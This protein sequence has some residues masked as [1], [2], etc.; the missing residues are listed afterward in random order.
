MKTV[1]LSRMTSNATQGADERLDEV[2][3]G[4]P[5]SSPIA[6]CPQ[7]ILTCIFDAAIEIMEGNDEFV[8]ATALSHVCKR[9]R[10]ISIY[11]PRL[12]RD[13]EIYCLNPIDDILSFLDRMHSRVKHKPVNIFIYDIDNSDDSDEEKE[14]DIRSNL[15]QFRLGRF[16]HIVYLRLEMWQGDSIYEHI[17]GPMPDAFEDCRIDELDLK[18][19]ADAEHPLSWELSS[20]LYRLPTVTFLFLDWV[21]SVTITP[22]DILKRIRFL[23]LSNMYLSLAPVL[24][25]FAHVEEL[26]FGPVKLMDDDQTLSSPLTMNHLRILD[27]TGIEEDPGDT[28]G[29]CLAQLTCPLLASLRIPELYIEECLDFISSHTS[30]IELDLVPSQLIADLIK[31]N[32]QLESFS[33]NVYDEAYEAIW[34]VVTGKPP[35][36]KLKKLT[37]IENESEIFS[38]DHFETLVTKRCLPLAHPQSQLLPSTEPIQQLILSLDKE[39]SKDPTWMENKLYIEA[40]KAISGRVI[41]LSWVSR[42]IAEI[43][44]VESIRLD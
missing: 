11:M 43:S 2:A 34:H 21:R 40:T 18:F 14:E 42:D 8:T 4:T 3:R 16:S 7:D 20:V 1:S 37:I 9:W 25:G 38:L 6:Q 10:D 23:F 15:I 27:I 36:P 35:F 44:V 5:A 30:I 24:Y 26:M 13:I 22:S 39:I 29:H 19:L 41:R 33:V 17:L 28:L 32:A 12:W 31:T